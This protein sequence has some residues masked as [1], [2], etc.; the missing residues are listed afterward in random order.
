MAREAQDEWLDGRQAGRQGRQ[1]DRQRVRPAALAV[2]AGHSL[3]H[4]RDSM[5]HIELGYVSLQGR[6]QRM[7]AVAALTADITGSRA[8]CST[9]QVE[10]W[11]CRAS[12]QSIRTD[13]AYHKG[14]AKEL[15]LHLPW[16]MAEAAA[17]RGPE[18]GPEQEPRLPAQQM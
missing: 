16:H 3:G 5:P 2:A 13:L 1:A 6:G 10:Q 17:G 14:R 8:S 4:N 11:S 12:P 9:N 7:V 18:K 15:Q